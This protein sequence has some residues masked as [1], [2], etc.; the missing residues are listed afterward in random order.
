MIFMIMLKGDHMACLPRGVICH[1]DCR[2][3]TIINKVL[4]S[5]LSLLLTLSSESIQI[6]HVELAQILHPWMEF[7]V[8][9]SV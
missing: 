2:P 8:H 7:V 1:T 3:E 9:W 4:L 6:L 5:I